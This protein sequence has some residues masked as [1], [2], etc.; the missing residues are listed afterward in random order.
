MVRTLSLSL[1]IVVSL[2]TSGCLSNPHSSLRPR[3]HRVSMKRAT[4][5][6][7][8][9][10]WF[11]D[12]RA[13]RQMRRQA[14]EWEKQMAHQ[15]AYQPIMGPG[16]YNPMMNGWGNPAVMAQPT[17]FPATDVAMMDMGMM[18]PAMMGMMTAD[19]GDC[20]CGMSSPMMEAPMGAMMDPQMMM[21][22]MMAAPVMGESGCGCGGGTSAGLPAEFHQ[23]SHMTGE[24]IEQSAPVLDPVQKPATESAGPANAQPGANDPGL[25]PMP[26][27]PQT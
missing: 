25:V 1:L 4:R 21:D 11:T 9:G 20:G 14:R 26:V 2:L 23:G 18:D 24:L 10:N 6:W 5:E 12:K 7:S 8:M 19:S 15:Q 16:V 3:N 13:E 27:A 17:Y 22:P